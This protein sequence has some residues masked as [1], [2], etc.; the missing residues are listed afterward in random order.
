MAKKEIQIPEATPELISKRTENAKTYDLGNGRFASNISLGAIHYKDNYSDPKELWKPIDLTI[1]KGR[2]DKAPYILEVKDNKTT[3]TCKKTGRQSVVEMQSI[4]TV[5]VS[6]DTLLDQK[7]VA[8]DTDYK[9]V[10]HPDKVKFQRT[11]LSDKAPLDAKFK[12]SGDLPIKYEAYDADGEPVNVKTSIK[13][14]ILTETIDQKSLKYPIKID[15]TI[16][17][18]TS[19][20]GHDI[21][22]Y[23]DSDSWE[24]GIT[25][26]SCSFGY[27]TNVD[28]KRGHGLWY[29]SGIPQGAVISTA[30]ITYT[31]RLSKSAT[32]INARFTGNKQVDPAVWSSFAAYAARR[33]TVVGGAN[34]NYI[35]TA[36]VDW[37]GVAAWTAG[38]TY[39]S[40]EIKTI[41]QELVNQGG[42]IGNIALFCDDHD[43]RGTQADNTARWAQS[44]DGDADKSPL[45]HVEY[46]VVIE[47]DACTDVTS[48][49]ATANADI[50]SAD[51]PIVRRG[52]V[53][54]KAAAGEPLITD[55]EATVI[56]EETQ[57]EV[58][59]L[60]LRKL[61]GEL[62]EDGYFTLDDIIDLGAV[63]TVRAH[64][65]LTTAAL[66]LY[67]DLY[68]YNNLY[69]VSNLYGT[70][71]GKVNVL[72]E[73]STT[74]DDTTADPEWGEW[75][76]FVIG[77]YSARGFR[78]RIHAEGLPPDITPVIY[79][80]YIELDMEDRVYSFE[81]TVLE[82]GIT[83]E[84]DPPFYAAPH[85]GISI[86]DAQSGDYYVI[87]TKD[88]NGF[89]VEIF[90]GATSVERAIS[91][92]ARGYG[93]K[94]V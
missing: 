59:G 40:P 2:M 23:W 86:L 53:Y 8:V 32:T 13:E 55:L 79:T 75:Q 81:E 42:F 25:S 18:D 21:S 38:T 90:N 94:E 52:F 50:I 82:D 88:E 35:T 76:T 12:I 26:T 84:F 65:I 69:T 67:D 5:D 91:G 43:A 92:I 47:T 64:G 83:I 56:S 10:L 24:G 73:I 85:I 70:S 61:N 4:G 17:V 34:N 37:D 57:S 19:A 9:L 89:N 15:P 14:G 77:D 16:D 63:F 36:Q 22:A 28:N 78:F 1:V 87:D 66:N 44:W 33:G 7:S 6:K 3:I 31:A 54:I 93:M 29:A 48:E 20:S 74:N 27:S 80:L 11:L 49:S 45:L 46:T 72:I 41:I 39:N 60:I 51:N 58:E 71:E 68:S 30:Y 62:E